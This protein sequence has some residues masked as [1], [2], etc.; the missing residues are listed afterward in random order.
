MVSFIFSLCHPVPSRT[1]VSNEAL[2]K[3][4]K[5][6]A[7]STC[8]HLSPRHRRV[9]QIFNRN[10]R[11]GRGLGLCSHGAQKYVH[12]RRL[13]YRRCGYRTRLPVAFS[14]RLPRH[15]VRNGW[16]SFIFLTWR[17]SH[18][19]RKSSLDRRLGPGLVRRWFVCRVVYKTGVALN[20]CPHV[21]RSL[22]LPPTWVT[23][24]LAAVV[25]GEGQGLS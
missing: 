1:T 16:S 18:L 3:H 12:C 19:F 14:V 23:V 5:T 7:S 24:D 4:G 9:W 15:P 10:K 11:C 22:L 2:R 13:H 20:L 8:L 6:T 17:R 21:T 25:A